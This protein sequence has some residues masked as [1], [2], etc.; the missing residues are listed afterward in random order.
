MIPPAEHLKLPDVEDIK[1]GVIAS[2][3]AAHSA[4]LARGN[5]QAWERDEKMSRARQKRDWETQIMLSLDPKK[6]RKNR[7]R[8]EPKTPD[9]CTM[10]GKFCSM[11][12]LD[13]TKKRA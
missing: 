5:I 10:C 12:L 11:K 1:Q 13:G 6:T 2:K 3:I 9:V 8:S 7:K 4:D